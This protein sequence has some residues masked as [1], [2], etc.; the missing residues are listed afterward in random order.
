MKDLRGLTLSET[1]EIVRA[2]GEPRF[3]GKQ[4]FQWVSRGVTD[5]GEMRNLPK[6]LRQNLAEKYRIDSLRVIRDLQSRSD[7]TRKFLFALE[8]GN[9]VESVFMKYSYGNTVCVS[10]QAGC[11]M[12]CAFCA[13]GIDGLR[14]NLTA[15]EMISQIL[16][17]E[18]V[19]GEKV[20]RTV[21]MGTGE[22]FDN[23]DELAK[24]IRVMNDADGR[25][26]GMRNFTVS[27]C[28]LVPEML[29]FAGDFPQVNLAVSLHAPTDEQ[30]S[31]I[32]PVN[33]RYPLRELMEAAEKYETVT[34]RRVTF[35]YALIRGV[36]D[37]DRD[38]KQL[39]RLLSGTLCH[40]N[41]IPLN[42]V[43]ETGFVTAGRER[44]KAIQ[45]TLEQNGIPA[46]VRRQLGADIDGACG[47]LRLENSQ[48]YIE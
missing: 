19:T 30:R 23:Y 13:S 20:S 45:K 5:F 27:T 6:T 35:E 38:V 43:S 12:G 48:K 18:R 24:F 11:R 26:M 7:G 25:N 41:L 1:E 33:R 34:S 4:L 40:V 16:D 37:R 29:R 9:A 10:S 14:R 44:A 47:Q 36:N 32:M 39:I 3:R 22:P 21:I 8:D 31:R 28:G 46:T 15:G 2:E 17:I 42:E